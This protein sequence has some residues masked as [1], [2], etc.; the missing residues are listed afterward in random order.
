M[1][2]IMCTSAPALR[3]SV[4]VPADP[5]AA[6]ATSE[7]GPASNDSRRECN[8][9]PACR[10]SRPHRQTIIGSVGGGGRSV[11]CALRGDRWLH[12]ALAVLA[13]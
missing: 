2:P 5:A 8:S 6:I 4:S 10:A 1:A 9:G 3:P 13:V 11:L 12:D 7:V